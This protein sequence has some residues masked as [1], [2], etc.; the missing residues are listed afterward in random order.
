MVMWRGVGGR[1]RNGGRV[2]NGR[3]GGSETEGER[4]RREGEE[5]RT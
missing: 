1:G 4:W 5:D 2:G 3:G